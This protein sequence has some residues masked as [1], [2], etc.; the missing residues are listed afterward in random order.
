MSK[1]ITAVR[2]PSGRFR[3]VKSGIEITG[4]PALEEWVEAVEVVKN[5]A[6]VS[7]LALAGLYAYGKSRPEWAEEFYQVTEGYD[8]RTV[9]NWSS[10]SVKPEILAEAPSIGHADAVTVAT[11]L[12]TAGD[13][14][15]GA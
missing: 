7:P 14:P 8:K 1:S 9:E 12:A 15:S 6:R 13:D 10:L 11:P 2:F 5:M 3:L 4:E